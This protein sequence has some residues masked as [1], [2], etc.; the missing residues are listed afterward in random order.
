MILFDLGQIY[1][2]NSTVKEGDPFLIICRMSLSQ[3]VQWQ[4][5]NVPINDKNKLGIPHDYIIEEVEEGSTVFAHLR[6]KS[7]RPLHSGAYRC[8]SSHTESHRLFVE[9]GKT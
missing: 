3:A 7:A 6:V 2:G 5:D 1:D 9:S 4:K 8:H